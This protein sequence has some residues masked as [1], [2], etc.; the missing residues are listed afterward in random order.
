[1]TDS[2]IRRLVLVRLRE[3]IVAAY[4]T[5]RAAAHALGGRA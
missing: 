5:V 4:T 1:M 2:I 3:R